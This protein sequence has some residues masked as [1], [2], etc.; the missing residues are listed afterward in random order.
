MP[1]DRP[2]IADPGGQVPVFYNPAVI[3]P[4]AAAAGA[5]IGGL[6]AGKIKEGEQRRANRRACLMTRGWRLVEPSDADGA[7]I[8]AMTPE[9]RSDHFAAVVGASTVAGEVTERTRFDLAADP[10]LVL[11]GPVA[12]PGQL[13]LGKKVDVAKP[14]GLA[15]GQGALVIAF[16]RPD[17]GSA[18]RSGSLALA[19]YDVEGRDLVCRPRDW[20]KKGDTTTYNAGVSS[21]D[22]KA[23]YE[24]HVIKLT[25]GDYVISSTSVG[26][27]SSAVMSALV[28]GAAPVASTYCFGAPT[29]RVNAGEVVYAG[30]IVPF[31]NAR[32]SIGGRVTSLGHTRHLEDARQT[33]ATHQPALAAALKP[34]ELRNGATFACVGTSMDRWDVPDAP[35][36]A[37]VD[38]ERSTS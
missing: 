36:L 4:V 20:K 34:A 24:V 17:D 21:V 10:L 23:G 15:A 19:R 16:R 29:V 3:S 28:G 14:F 35:L 8:K 11:D 12:V 33:L 38:K 9:Q 31:A 22:K 13:Q 2:R 25:A 5:G 26:G 6:I 18:G 7:R 27:G 37:P 1:F 30:D 32:T